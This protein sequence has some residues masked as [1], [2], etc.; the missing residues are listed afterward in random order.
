MGAIW[1]GLKSGLT[2]GWNPQIKG[3]LAQ[4]GLQ[5][6]IPY[7]TDDQ[8][9]AVE[10]AGGTSGAYTA[11]AN[12]ERA[13]RQAAQ[14]QHPYAYGGAELAGA[15]APMAVAPEA[16]GPALLAR[17]VQALKVGAAYGAASGASDAAN[18][19][20]TVAGMLA[21]TA[22][23]AAT[24]AAGGV[25]G[26][27]V[28]E[29][30]GRATSWAASPILSTIKGW[31]NPTAEAARSVASSIVGS[32]ER[33]ASGSTVGGMTPAQW[34]TARAS[35]EPVMIA[36][37][38]GV[39]T[40]ALMR[41]A[42]NVSPDAREQIEA[43]V[44][45]RFNSQADRASSTIRSL[46]P[47]GVNAARSRAQAE[48]EYDAE[49][50]GAY[51][52][53][54]QAGDR[55]IWSPE[56]ER[57]TA[58][59][60]IQQALRGAV[61]T[62]RDWQV[63]DGFGAMNPPVR[64]TPDGQ[65]QF[66]GGRGLSPYPNLQMWDYTQRIIS[67]A[68][69]SA[70]PGSQEAARLGGLASLLRNELDRQVPEFAQARGVAANFFGSNN[71][72]DAGVDAVNY[73]GDLED[74]RRTVAAMR[75]N[76]R[77]MFAESYADSLARKVEQ[78]SDRQDVSARVLNNP[79]ERRKFG[80]IMG[81]GGAS[82]MGAFLSR[83]AVYDAARKA[84]GNS[85]T[86]RQMIEAGLAGGIGD[87]ALTG[88]PRQAVLASLG[89][90]GLG[91]GAAMSGLVRQGISGGAKTA[92]GYVN[93]NLAREVAR[94]LTS[95]DPRDLREGLRM[96]SRNANVRQG[97]FNIA[98]R[99]A[100]ATGIA[101]APRLQLPEPVAAEGNQPEIPRPPAQQQAGGAV[102]GQAPAIQ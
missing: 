66:T 59:P 65:L 62:W 34:A 23:G 78:I 61:N 84:L 39:P 10:A 49:R 51:Q 21:D 57:L 6:A 88:D 96:A 19:G 35:G 30:L 74:L 93:R 47:G 27:L 75:P 81:P 43:A 99:V 7:L 25:G 94:L 1:Q 91:Y 32:Q 4:L 85:T 80:M 64:V 72:M 53:A 28:G 79:Y 38:G 52:T 60:S 92:V 55:P 46:M 41:W 29:G 8:L 42:A 73:K 98:G 68:A 14:T 67:D 48:A 36:D 71:A 9:K 40:K 33:I 77:E 54:Y 31:L 45:D 12:A 13:S 101:K 102:N 90:A 20:D 22:V 87:Y 83:E 82:T 26:T 37:L 86:V 95:S 3:S 76:E 44:N 56:L 70:E 2:A 16:E 97:L 15:I 18:K 100:G 69:R 24:G 50:T 63:R 89:G 5:E 11:A 17:G 58:A